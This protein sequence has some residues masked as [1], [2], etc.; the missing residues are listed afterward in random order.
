MLTFRAPL[1]LQFKQLDHAVGLS[2]RNN[3]HFALVGHLIKGFRH[4]SPPIVSRTS[5]IITT[6]LSIVARPG[7]SDKFVVNTD[8]VAYLTGTEQFQV[9]ESMGICVPA[10]SQL[11][12]FTKRS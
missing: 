4:E 5:R 12:R 10:F 9:T 2:F 8:N 1:E 3:F 11:S 7:Q 6:L